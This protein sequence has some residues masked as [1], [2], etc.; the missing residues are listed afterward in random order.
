MS[1]DVLSS[2]RNLVPSD[3]DGDLIALSVSQLRDEIVAL[4]NGIRLH[5]DERGNDR[6][7]LD[8]GRLYGMFPEAKTAVTKLPDWP[9]FCGNCRRFWEQRQNPSE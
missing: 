2:V 7:W 3:D 6:C 8:D 5:R 1:D 4:R 9:E